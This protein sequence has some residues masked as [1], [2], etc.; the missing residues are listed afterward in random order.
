[1]QGN[2]TISGFIDNVNQFTNGMLVGMFMIAIFI[3]MLMIMKNWEFDKSILTSS[4]LCLVISIMLKMAGWINWM[5]VVFFFIIMTTS[6]LY[7][8]AVKK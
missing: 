1:M 2:A 3:S 4:F 5:Y 7:L 8:Y 6:G